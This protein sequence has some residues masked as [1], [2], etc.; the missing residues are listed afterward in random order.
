M[1]PPRAVLNDGTR[2]GG[3]VDGADG[4]DPVPSAAAVGLR[5][6]ALV[7]GGVRAAGAGQEGDSRAGSTG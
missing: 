7:A 4:S 5:G 1:L 3:V 2:G 6:A